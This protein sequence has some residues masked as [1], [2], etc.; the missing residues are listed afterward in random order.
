MQTDVL[1]KA[2][3]AGGEGDQAA[4]ISKGPLC[5]YKLQRDAS[6]IADGDMKDPAHIQITFVEPKGGCLT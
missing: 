4:V 5:P 3:R 1:P 2:I 6:D